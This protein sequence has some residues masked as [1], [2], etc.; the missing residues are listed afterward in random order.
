MLLKTKQDDELRLVM[1]LTKQ[2]QPNYI[3]SIPEKTKD[4]FASRSELSIFG[5]NLLFCERIVITGKLR[6]E[7]LETISAASVQQLLYGDM[8][9][10]RI[11]QQTDRLW[12]LSD[13][14]TNPEEGTAEKY[15]TARASLVENRSQL[16]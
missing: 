5:G 14:E 12:N 2:I 13:T 3:N 4:Y 8:G 16:V 9:Y 11:W 7:I 10:L 15:Y 1:N 6:S